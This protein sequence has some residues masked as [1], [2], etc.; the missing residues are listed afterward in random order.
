VD[1]AAQE[2]PRKLVDDRSLPVGQH[3][4]PVVLAT[5]TG[6][7]KHVRPMARVAADDHALMLPMPGGRDSAVDRRELRR[8]DRVRDDLGITGVECDAQ[9]GGPRHERDVAVAEIEPE[10]IG[11]APRVGGSPRHEHMFA[12]ASD[13]IA[14]IAQPAGLGG[15]V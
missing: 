7:G 14:T 10:Q 15:L 5:W 13:G 1:E 12:H 8:S 6:L 3:D 4:R 9:V 2:R 11:V